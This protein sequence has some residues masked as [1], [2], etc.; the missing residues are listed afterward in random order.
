M[1]ITILLSLL[2]IFLD[3]FFVA[4][5]NFR[6]LPIIT[7]ALYGKINW[8]YL[9]I[10]IS[11]VSIALD[12]VYHYVLGTNLLILA[13]I[14]FLGRVV[15]LLIPWGYNLG[16]YILKYVGFTLYY[17][18][19]AIIPSLISTGT[20]GLISWGNIGGAFL[21]GIFSLAICLGIDMVWGRIRSKGNSNKLKLI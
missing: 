15:S 17:V 21:K 7:I 10:T 13:I 19:L 18:L 6:I 5:A 9:L 20:L 2:T 11:L 3:S 8:K 12:V 14:L 4:L 1:A 16:S